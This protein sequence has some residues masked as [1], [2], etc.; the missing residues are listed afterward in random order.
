MRTRT[1]PIVC[2]AVALL[3]LTPQLSGAAAPG[4][5]A[6][7]PTVV[8][9]SG[10][11]PY[12]DDDR[13]APRELGV[14]SARSPIHAAMKARAARLAARLRSS[15]GR[16]AASARVTP[17]S[18]GASWE[19]VDDLTNSPPD[20][21]G[22]VGPKSY[23]EII[24][25]QIGI[26][27]RT[28]AVTATGNLQTLTGHSQF[29]LTDPMV[30]WDPDTQ[31]FYY[32]VWDTSQASMA[33][34]FSKTK[35]PADLGASWCK[36]TATFGY[37]SSQA[38]DYPKFGQTKDFLLI[39]VN[40]YPAFSSPLSTQSDL[41]WVSKPPGS[42]ALTTCPS[43]T[44]FKAGKFSNLLNV[45][46]S[47]AFTPVPAIQADPASQGWVVASADV[48]DGSPGDFITL[49][50]VRPKTSDPT[51]PV[52]SAP[53]EITVPTY[54]GGPDAPQKGTDRLLDTLDGRFKHAVSSIDPRTGKNMVWTSHTVLGGA[55]TEARWYEIKPT[56]L[57]SPSVFQKGKASHPDLFVFNDGISSDRTVKPSGTAHGSSMVMGFTTS[58][59]DTFPA[60]RM[61]SK[62]GASAQSAFV[63]VKGSPGKNEDFT[64]TS[65]GSTCRWG[66]YGG[67]TPDPGASLTATSGAVWLTNEW[68]VASTNPNGVWWR[69]WNWKATP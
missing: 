43:A 23:I 33:F 50:Q 66:D 68:N 13:A 3:A 27:T 56:P 8:S 31:R 58:S 44:T 29:N 51:V 69:T 21:N 6:R 53:H 35:N 17:P 14:V 37:A 67:A 19:G 59:S 39:G 38:P 65:A 15:A 41:L 20:T 64:C 9:A 16:S 1:S 36:Y 18:I 34:G 12:G 26:Y 46:G 54:R 11:Q 10:L 47:Q 24:N 2:A 7:R 55:G 49:F 42:D 52:I 40:F 60:I 5:H 48:E 25:I 4:R 28:G 61:V 22:A 30:F 62:V 63:R 32:N 45:D 57:G